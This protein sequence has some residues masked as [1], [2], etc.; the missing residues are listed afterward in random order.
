MVC[1]GMVWYGM[2]WY[3]MVWYGYWL[4][5]YIVCLSI[6][7][8]LASLLPHLPLGHIWVWKYI[9]RLHFLEMLKHT[10]LHFWPGKHILCKRKKLSAEL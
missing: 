6:L 4:L 5:V 2:V 7:T 1:Y 9:F 10:V 8:F 3:D